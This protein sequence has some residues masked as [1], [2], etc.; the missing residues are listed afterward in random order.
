LAIHSNVVVSLPGTRR[1]RRLPPQ[2]PCCH[3]SPGW[4]T[5]GCPSEIYQSSKAMGKQTMLYNVHVDTKLLCF[6]L[7]HVENEKKF[8]EPP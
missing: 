6:S 4:W 5:A 2:C 7:L 3:S 1:A 8:L